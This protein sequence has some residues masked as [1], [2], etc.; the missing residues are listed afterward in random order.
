MAAKRPS[1]FKQHFEQ[2]LAE[3]RQQQQLDAARKPQRVSGLRPA[4]PVA[5]PAEAT[6]PSANIELRFHADMQRLKDIQSIDSRI[7]LKAE[8]LPH[9]H[10]WI[11]GVLA[12]SNPIQ[13]DMLMHLMVWNIDVGDY[14][15]ALRIG[16]Y[17]MLNG[18][19]MPEPYKRSVASILAEQISDGLLQDPD[20][21]PEHLALIERTVELTTPEDMVDQIRAK[22]F[23]CLGLALIQARPKEALAALESAKRLHKS[24]GVTP[25]INKLR[26]QFNS[27]AVLD[28]DKDDE[29]IE[30]ESSRDAPSGSQDTTS[31][32]DAPVADPA[33]TAPSADTGA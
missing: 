2:A 20:G 13:N 18:Y 23:K 22:L 21:M 17:A 19:V 29:S 27:Q 11:D 12:V 7:A 15:L 4:P 32:S 5:E 30:P 10:G 1:I 14:E 9:Y 25:Q 24:V 28:D 31:T 26:K 3:K 16:E 6:N 33:S 8:M